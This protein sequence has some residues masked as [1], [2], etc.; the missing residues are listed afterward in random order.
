M[1]N[2]TKE[3]RAR[4]AS[5]W[6]SSLFLSFSLS[7]CGC[8]GPTSVTGTVSYNDRPLEQGYVT[9]HP[10]DDVGATRGAEIKG[11]RYEIANLPPGRKR[12]QITS[13][14]RA[15]SVIDPRTGT[16]RLHVQPGPQAVVTNAAGNFQVLE[17]EAGTQV[18]DFHLRS[19]GR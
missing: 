2:T 11:G 4:Q 16:P 7:V 5:L 15:T 19:P 6:L 1:N 13:Q 8:R 17:V 9:F 14:P 3:R 10:V 18:Y 12:V